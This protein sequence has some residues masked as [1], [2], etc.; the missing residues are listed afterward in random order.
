MPVSQRSRQRRATHSSRKREQPRLL[1]ALPA[2]LNDNQ[3]LTFK[4]WTALNGISARTGRRILKAPG[5]P[6]VTRLSA[7]RFGI[8]V[9]NNRR[10]QQSREA[11]S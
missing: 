7:R 8:T 5:G 9:A 6:V 4:Q 10:W 11:A 2:I 1:P 3:V